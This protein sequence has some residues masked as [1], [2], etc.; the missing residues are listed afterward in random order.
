MAKYRQMNL[1]LE[2]REKK[3]ILNKTFLKEKK[4]HNKTKLEERSN[5]G[6]R[7]RRLFLYTG[8]LSEQA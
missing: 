7:F 5:K 6:K 2:K 8:H 3:K 4:K 1:N